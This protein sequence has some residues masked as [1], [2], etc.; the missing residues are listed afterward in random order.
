M[1]WLWHQTTQREA[2]DNTT[3]HNTQRDYTRETTTATL[4]PPISP[5]LKSSRPRVKKNCDEFQEKA[6]FLD[7]YFSDV[8]YLCF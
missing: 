3:Q 4:A 6:Q 8:G 2:S 7:I 5:A 1:R